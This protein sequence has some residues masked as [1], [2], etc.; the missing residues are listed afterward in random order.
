MTEDQF[1][2]LLD[3]HGGDLERWPRATLREARRLLAQSVAAQAMLDELVAVELALTETDGDAAPP[4]DLADRIFE[5]AFGV[6]TASSD[7]LTPDAAPVPGTS[8][9]V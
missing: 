9:P 6:R 2:E 3:R 5:R 4:A 1:R 8:R 7:A